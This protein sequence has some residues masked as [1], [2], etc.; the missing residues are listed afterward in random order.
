MIQGYWWRCFIMLAYQVGVTLFTT[1]PTK[2]C[3]IP[4]SMPWC[5]YDSQT[6]MQSDHWKPNICCPWCHCNQQW[7]PH[8]LPLVL[9]RPV[10]DFLWWHQKMLL[11]SSWANN[12]F[13]LHFLCFNKFLQPSLNPLAYKPLWNKYNLNL[14]QQ[15]I[16]SREPLKTLT[17][18]H[19]QQGEESLKPSISITG[20]LPTNPTAPRTSN[21]LLW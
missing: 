15:L 3:G 8:C 21:K 18:Q 2:S 12:W 13:L 20:W 4:T 14:Y 9:Q 16:G 5:T 17:R 7:Q 19:Y 1:T 6:N 10:Q 11:V